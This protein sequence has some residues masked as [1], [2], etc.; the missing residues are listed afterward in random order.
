MEKAAELLRLT[1][2]PSYMIAEK[3][4]YDN[5]NYFGRLFKKRYGVSTSEYR[6]NL[7]KV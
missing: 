4:G 7:R 3:V 2:L 6:K 1:D 5:F